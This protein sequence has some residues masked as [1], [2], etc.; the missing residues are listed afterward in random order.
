MMEAIP[1][2]PAFPF[3]DVVWASQADGQRSGFPM[4]AYLMT[5]LVLA[6]DMVEYV[7]Q[8]QYCVQNP[9]LAVTSAEVRTKYTPFSSCGSAPDT[10]ASSTTWRIWA[11]LSE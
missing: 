8:P 5:L 1:S 11:S 2:A 4:N 6:T 9:E 10:I 7:C 3:G